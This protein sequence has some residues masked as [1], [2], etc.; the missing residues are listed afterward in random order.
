MSLPASLFKI[1]DFTSGVSFLVDTGFQISILPASKWDR[2]NH[3]RSQ[4]LMAANG[5]AIATFGPRTLPL[6]FGKNQFQW[7]FRVADVTQPI[8]EAD[9]LC[10]HSLMVDVGGCRFVNIEDFGT[11]RI[12]VGFQ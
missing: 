1:Y 3:D 4:D 11:M 12:R 9:F 6:C 7:L 5:T 10:A 2:E 8:L